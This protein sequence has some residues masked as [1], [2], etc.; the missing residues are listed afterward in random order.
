M[1]LFVARSAQ[2]VIDAAVEEGAKWERMCFGLVIA[3]GLVA[4]GVMVTGAVLREGLVALSGGVG[5]AGVLGSLLAYANGVRRDKV[6]IRLYE[7]AL[8]KAQTATEAA[9]I[10]REALGRGPG[11]GSKS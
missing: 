2:T 10:L 5:G 11:S 6:R 3:A 8:A 1:G 9:A 4:L 7:I